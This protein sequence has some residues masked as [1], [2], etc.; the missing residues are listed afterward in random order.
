MQDTHGRDK[1]SKSRI[2]SVDVFRLLA[3]AAV[4]A[5]HTAGFKT[6]APDDHKL[7]SYVYLAINQIGRYSVSFFFAISGFFWGLKILHGSAPISS[8]NKMCIKIASIYVAWSFIY[9]FS[10]N[11]SAGFIDYG[12]LG[13]IKQFYWNLLRVAH[14]PVPLLSE[15]TRVH[16]WFLTALIWCVYISALFVHKYW[17]KSLVAL[18]VVLY[19]FGVLANAYA[20]TPIGIPIG[21]NTRNGP[22]LGLLPFV[23]GLLLSREKISPQWFRNGSVIFILGLALTYCEN[24][25]LRNSFTDLRTLEYVFGTVIMGVGAA[26][27]SLS[28]NKYL[29]INCLSNMG[30]YTLGIYAIH[31]VFIDL[32]H[33]V[34]KMLNT[35][36]CEVI[37]VLIVLLFSYFAVMLLEKNRF[38]KN[39]VV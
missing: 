22:F 37:Y 8:A 16:L 20:N 24:F 34:N 38:T 32:L 4:I 5:G 18:S 10:F 26:V 6:D 14:N 23:L 35:P 15:G 39:I 2:Q 36:I 31:M 11:I 17:L 9:L 3:I 28:D 30:K 12:W 1:S 19:I 7:Y 29:S 13:P 25:F 27:A 21:F 33:N